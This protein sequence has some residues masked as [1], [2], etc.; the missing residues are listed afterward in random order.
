MPACPHVQNVLPASHL[1]LVFLSACKTAFGASS[2]ADATVGLPRALLANG[3]RTVVASM[4]RLDDGSTEWLVRRFYHHLL[5]DH[6]HPSVARALHLAMIDTSLRPDWS[7]PYFWAG[8]QV[9]GGY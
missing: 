8:L 9:V 3:A 4:W 1:Q 7:G 5:R 2:R 6:D